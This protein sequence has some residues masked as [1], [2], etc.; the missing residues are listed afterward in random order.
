M[1]I[2][3][4]WSYSIGLGSKGIKGARLYKVEVAVGVRVRVRGRVRFRVRFRVSV[5][6]RVSAIQGQG[7]I[8]V[9]VWSTPRLPSLP[10]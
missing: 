1:V 9:I 5:R 8:L 2:K 4:G 6:V 10:E 3:G 7:V